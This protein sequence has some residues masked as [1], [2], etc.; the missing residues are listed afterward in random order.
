MK[1]CTPGLVPLLDISGSKNKM[2]EAV[3]G[4]FIRYAFKS[5]IQKRYHN[6][7]SINLGG[8]TIN[9]GEFGWVWLGLGEFW[10]GLG[11]F[12]W[13]WVSLARF[14]VGARFRTALNLFSQICY[15]YVSHFREKIIYNI[16]LNI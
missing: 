7:Y 2:A 15:N 13:V 4:D 16:S 8:C 9:L 14:G 11:G 6:F 10:L 12:G 1:N 3:S 5:N